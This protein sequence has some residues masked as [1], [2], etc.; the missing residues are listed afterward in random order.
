MTIEPLF[1]ADDNDWVVMVG[2]YMLNMG[3]IEAATRLLIS[4]CEQTD[5]SSV[6]NT[7][8]PSRLGFL[9]KR[10]PRANPMRHSWAMNIFRV[11]DKHV[12][13]RNIIAHS[14]I[15]IT[16]HEDGSRHIRGILN[17]T[18]NDPNNVGQLVELDELRGRVNESAQLA[19][20]LLEMQVN[21]NAKGSA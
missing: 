7:E 15:M 16:G 20:S 14:P 3:A 6:M 13:F 1:N 19:R 12:G 11:A 4:M 5:R 17:L 9:K 8:L 18:P 10:F 2:R 21:F